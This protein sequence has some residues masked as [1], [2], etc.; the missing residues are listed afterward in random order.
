[1][2]TRR[3]A[4][5][6][7]R[8]LQRAFFASLVGQGDAAVLRHVMADG[9]SAEARL[10][11]HRDTFIGSLTATLRLSFPAVER[12]V[13]T[14][15]FE[16]A[17]RVFIERFPPRS[18]DLT[19]YGARLPAF[20]EGFEPAASLPYLADVARLE[21][22]VSS[23]INAPDAE[24][25]DLARLSRLSSR[26]RG[27]VVLIPDPSL[28]LVRANHRVDEIWR[29]VLCADDAALAA[30]DPGPCPVRVLVERSG[31]GVDVVRLNA[32]EAD[33]FE[34]LCAGKTLE[35]AVAE[36]AALVDV[37]AALAGHLAAGRFV[38]FAL[39]GGRGSASDEASRT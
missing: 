30:I 24:R 34:R 4:T 17:A 6:T 11:I 22:A 39:G 29:A 10:E 15:F 21:W 20:L 37:S 36:T 27:R 32:T 12:L 8:D 2:H 31:S 16:S 13:G 23:A 9:I 19:A 26:E 18:A 5:P 7:L 1:M 33:F 25:L 3:S 28:A 38:D 14:A 35:A